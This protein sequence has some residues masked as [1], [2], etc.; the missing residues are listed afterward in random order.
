MLALPYGGGGNTRAYAR[1]FDEAGVGGRGCSPCSRASAPRRSATAIRIVAARPPRAGRG[2][3]RGRHRAPTRSCSS[4]GRRSRGSRGSSASRRRPRASPAS[5]RFGRA[6]ACLRAHRPRAEGSRRGRAALRVAGAGDDGQ[7]RAGLRLRGGRARSLERGRGHA[8]ARRAAR[9]GAHRHPRLRARRLAG[10]ARVRVDRPDSARA[11]ARLERG[12]DRARAGRRGE[13]VGSGARARGPARAR[14][15]ARGPLRQPRRLPRRRCLP[16]LGR[17]DRAARRHAAAHAR[18]RSSRAR[19]C[20]RPRRGIAL[21]AE[22]PHA[23]AAFTV[24]RAALLGAGIAARRRRPCSRPRSPTGSTSP[25]GPRRSSTR[26]ARSC[27][28]G[29]VGA[30]LS[31]SGPT[32]IVW[33]EDA[34]AVRGRA[35]GPLPRRDG[36]RRCAV[37]AE[38]AH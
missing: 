1:G 20:G 21:P 7:P 14:R 12:D 18:S 32:V 4:G 36:A 30:T 33:A 13:V 38:G 5:R 26:S 28:R 19:R 9:P 34:D 25:T 6:G 37:S 27:P 29:A 11:R 8:R 16:D 22:V 23:D 15:A 17:A 31:G 2:G 10:G 35:R 3:G 24:A